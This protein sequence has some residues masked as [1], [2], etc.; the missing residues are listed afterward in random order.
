MPSRLVAAYL[1]CLKTQRKLSAHTVAAYGRDLQQLLQL[2]EALP[3]RP[4]LRDLRQ[5]QVRAL[6]ARLH[7]CGLG[8][9]SIA[10]KLSSWRGFYGW[11]AE[12]EAP[13]ARLAANPVDGVKAPRRNKPLPKALSTDDAVRLVAQGAPGKNPQDPAESCNRAMFELLYSS[14]LRISEL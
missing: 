13:A 7:A 6:A 3:E 2:A 14:G 1:D 11:L 10:R 9:R 5:H 8:P 12:N 4:A